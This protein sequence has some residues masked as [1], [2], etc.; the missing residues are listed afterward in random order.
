MENNINGELFPELI[1]SS[2]AHTSMNVSVKTPPSTVGPAK[3]IKSSG[4]KR[5]GGIKMRYSTEERA[6]WIAEW[7]KSGQRAWQY[8]KANG[9]KPQ[10]FM[11]WTK[12]ESEK[13]LE[14]VEVK[15]PEVSDEREKIEILIEK[16]EMRIHIPVSIGC[17][18]RRA[19]MSGLGGIA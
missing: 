15:M 9:L 14:F 11:R 10:T 12:E 6:K 8:A 16:G 19:I 1:S 13:R 18:E 7:K 3:V 17:N 4:V 5:P 2:K